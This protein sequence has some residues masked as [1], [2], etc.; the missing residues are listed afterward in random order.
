MRGIVEER[1][2]MLGEYILQ[3]KAT[4]REVAKKFAV[5]KSTVHIDVI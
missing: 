5:S 1:A 4:V 2:V 3:S